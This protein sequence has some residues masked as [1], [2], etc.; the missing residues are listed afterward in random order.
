MVLYLK[1]QD[2]STGVQVYIGLT[3]VILTCSV[4]ISIFLV[5]YLTDT[6]DNSFFSSFFFFSWKQMSNLCV[7]ACCC[8]PH[9]VLV[10]WPDVQAV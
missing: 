10:D 3:L 7:V 4:S 6:L 1:I 8:A 5:Y 9:S 2:F